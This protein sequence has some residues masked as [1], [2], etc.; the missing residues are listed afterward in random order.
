M[1]A[2]TEGPYRGR[3]KRVCESISSQVS[4]LTERYAKPLPKIN[5]NIEKLS[6]EVDFFL[7]AMGI[8]L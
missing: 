8:K 3:N 5:E 4:V 2:G 7:K 1:V 6:G